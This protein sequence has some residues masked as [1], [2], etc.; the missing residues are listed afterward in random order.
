MTDVTVTQPEVALVT[1]A[2][3]ASDLLSLHESIA[4]LLATQGDYRRAYQ[5]LRAALDLSRAAAGQLG[6]LDAGVADVRLDVL[7]A[8]AVSVVAPP[9]SQRARPRPT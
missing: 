8:A 3:S 5:H 2:T 6:V 7:N 4:G 1:S 9:P